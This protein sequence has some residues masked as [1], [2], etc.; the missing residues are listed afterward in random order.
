MPTSCW[1]RGLMKS[2]LT[3]PSMTSSACRFIRRRA[4]SPPVDSGETSTSRM[5]DEAATFSDV[6][7]VILTPTTQLPYPEKQLREHLDKTSRELLKE[8]NKVRYGNKR[9]ATSGIAFTHIPIEKHVVLLFPGQG[10]QFVGMGEKLE[11]IPEAKKVFDT[12]SE[13]LGYDMLELCKKGPKTKLD[14][15]L[16]CQPSVVTCG[17]AAFE[18]FKAQEPGVAEFIT[19]VAGFSVGEYAALVAGDMMSFEDVIK[20]VKVRAEAMHEC[21]QLIR[22]GMATVRVKAASRL[23]EAMQDARDVA[24]EKGELD[25]CEIA[26]FLFCGVRV[27]GGSETCLKFLE[28]HQNEYQFQVVKRLAVSAAFHTRQMDDAVVKVRTAVARAELKYPACNVYSNYTG[29]IFPAKKGEIRAALAKQVNNPVKWEQIQQLLYRK[30][31]EDLFPRFVEVGPGRQLGA[32]LLQTSKK[33]ITDGRS[34][35]SLSVHG[36]HRRSASFQPHRPC[37]VRDKCNVAPSE[38]GAA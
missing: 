20:I 18:A 9:K 23:E 17:V 33:A 15:T 3:S 22:S 25:V 34:A 4:P 24:K 11:S 19:D 28:E 10:A 2:L 14:Q 8:R 30:K 13:V 21:G 27:I 16:Y 29:H 32:M 6:H 38:S 35:M 5:L 7:N 36:R 31:Q 37:T 26:N 1:S 12:A